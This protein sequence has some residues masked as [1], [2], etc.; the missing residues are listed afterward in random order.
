MEKRESN[1]SERT[2]SQLTEKAEKNIEEI[3][4][5]YIKK[6]FNKVLNILK[7]MVEEDADEYREVGDKKIGNVRVQHR[8]RIR[9]LDDKK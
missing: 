2:R 7:K 1:A 6:G 8:L 3:P 9:F 4:K 5:Q